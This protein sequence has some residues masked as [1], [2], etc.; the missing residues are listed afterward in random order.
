MDEN[1]DESVECNRCCRPEEGCLPGLVCVTQ[2]QVEF[3]TRIMYFVGKSGDLW[4]I[5]SP[6]A[7]APTLSRVRRRNSELATN[8]PA[9][10]VRAM[11]IMNVEEDLEETES[12]VAVRAA[13]WRFKKIAIT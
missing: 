12:T 1:R 13:C 7:S 11:V 2:F 10:L 3:G 9:R 8:E 6:A 5:A 4:T